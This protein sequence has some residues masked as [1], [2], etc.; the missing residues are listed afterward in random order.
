MKR[1]AGEQ[2]NKLPFT[3]L[4]E[5]TFT[6]MNTNDDYIKAKKNENYVHV[7]PEDIIR[8]CGSAYYV[9]S[10]EDDD[11]TKFIVHCENC[12]LEVCFYRQVLAYMHSDEGLRFLSYSIEQEK[13]NDKYCMRD[14]IVYKIENSCMVKWAAAEGCG[15]YEENSLI[16]YCIV[17]DNEFVDIIARGDSPTFKVTYNK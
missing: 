6:N 5:M 14:K 17:T 3:H 8:V 2:T 16:H 11:C 9:E 1:I 13:N 4:K 12:L 7:T 15:F 10:S